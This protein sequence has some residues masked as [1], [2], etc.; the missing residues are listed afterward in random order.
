MVQRYPNGRNN[1]EDTNQRVTYGYDTNAV[2]PGFSQYSQGRLATA[3][4]TVGALG[5]DHTMPVTE[6][7]SYHAAGAV[8]AKRMQVVK[9]GTDPNGDYGCGPGY[10]EADYTYNANGQMASYGTSFTQW[11]PTRPISDVVI[12]GTVQLRVRFHGEAGLAAGQ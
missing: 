4:Y 1:S 7:Y 6:M 11:A 8:T 10:V 2:N 9:C 3:Q 5:A 12:A